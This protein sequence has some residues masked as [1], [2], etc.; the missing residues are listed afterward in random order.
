MTNTDEDMHTSLSKRS[1]HGK[2]YGSGWAEPTTILPHGLDD[3]V[4]EANPST[5]TSAVSAQV[6][7]NIQ[8]VLPL[9][10][11]CVRA[12]CAGEEIV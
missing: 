11:P 3:H 7:V 2:G 6:E 9:T 5:F 8:R 10:P 4:P 12:A 1:L